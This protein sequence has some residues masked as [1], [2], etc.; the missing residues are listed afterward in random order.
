MCTISTACMYICSAQGGRKKVSGLLKLK[1]QANGNQLCGCWD[2][3]LVPL[4]DRQVLLI[5]SQISN[6]P[7]LVP[8]K[9][10]KFSG[11]TL[12]LDMVFIMPHSLK[13]Q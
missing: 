3:N 11:D 8:Q 1:F 5:A 6:P 10:A 2:V 7:I 4:Q 9:K 13:F 12:F